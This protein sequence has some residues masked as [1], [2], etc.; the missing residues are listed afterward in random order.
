M[1]APAQK[2]RGAW[3]YR[4]P[5]V[6]GRLISIYGTDSIL[7]GIWDRPLQAESR[8]GLTRGSAD[9]VGNRRAKKP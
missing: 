3:T 1:A 4:A 8:L 9:R 5:G 2:G 6:G 7:R